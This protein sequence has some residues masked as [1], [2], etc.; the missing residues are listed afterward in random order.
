MVMTKKEAIEAMERGEKVTHEQFNPEEW[1]SMEEGRL[2][3]D[4]GLHYD[5]HC[6]WYTRRGEDWD[7]G[8]SIWEDK[9][10]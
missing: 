4:D 10:N 5:S 6:F 7:D 3:S 8:W 9:T 2:V 1:I